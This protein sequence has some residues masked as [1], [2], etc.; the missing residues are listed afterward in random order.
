MRGW[1]SEEEL[2]EECCVVCTM[3]L[4]LRISLSIPR[5][6]MKKAGKKEE[7]KGKKEEGMVKTSKEYVI[8]KSLNGVMEYGCVAAGTISCLSS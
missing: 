5:A 2:Q 4:Y 6:C 8:C 3:T 7:R 1:T